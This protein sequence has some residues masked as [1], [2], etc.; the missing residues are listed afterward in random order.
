MQQ[1][2]KIP[3]GGDDGWRW[4]CTIFQP[5]IRYQGETFDK[6][7]GRVRHTGRQAIR[8]N[9]AG[10]G[11]FVFHIGTIGL[12]VTVMFFFYATL[13]EGAIIQK[14]TTNVVQKLF[15]DV[16]L[17]CTPEQQKQLVTFA[18]GLTVPTNT[19]DDQDACTKNQASRNMA[20]KVFL[21]V[22]AGSAAIMVLFCW[23]DVKSTGAYSGAQ[24]GDLVKRITYV[25]ATLFVMIGIAEYAFLT[26][27]AR[28]FITLD[29]NFVKRT[30]IGS[31]LAQLP[32]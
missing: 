4:L 31:I 24:L 18:T 32:G 26:C 8:F 1:A 17:V 2:K 10:V 19:Q 11:D 15:R 6:L 7:G 20:L 9:R 13:I 12:L 22:L 30:V 28:N 29:P 14:Q 21:P 3:Q 16:N 27:F 25:N 5:F 23:W